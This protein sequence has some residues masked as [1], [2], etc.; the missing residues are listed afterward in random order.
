MDAVEDAAQHPFPGRLN[1]L[2]F[3]QGHH[4]DFGD[5]EGKQETRPE[6]Q[7]RSAAAEAPG[8]KQGGCKHAR[9]PRKDCPSAASAPEQGG[10][11]LPPLDPASSSP[12]NMMPLISLSSPAP[13]AHYN[14]AP[15]TSQQAGEARPSL[16]QLASLESADIQLSP[17][18]P[19]ESG[20]EERQ[21][22]APQTAEPGAVHLDGPG[23]LGQLQLPQQQQREHFKSPGPLMDCQSAAIWRDASGACACACI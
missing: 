11:G 18:S 16:P 13:P 22:G 12:C 20:E 10:L 7:A 17:A 21:Q 14:S 23:F 19:R 15:P 5:G 6:Q 1:L 3:A 8:C 4:Q 9:T 2:V